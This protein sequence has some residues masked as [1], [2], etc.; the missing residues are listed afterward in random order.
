[1]AVVATNLKKGQCIN[2]K[3]EMGVVLGLDHRTPGKGNALIMAKIRSFQTG[4][5]KDI[6]FASSDKVDIVPA[7][8]KKVEYSYADGTGYFF[9]DPETYDTFEVP[10]DILGEDAGWLTENMEVEVLYVD[11]KLVSTEL[12]PSIEMEVTEAAEGLK[13]DTANNPQK[14]VTLSCGKTI[15]A[16][17]FVKEGD[18]VKV[19]P[20]SGEYLG[21]A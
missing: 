17:L 4:K 6:R 14:P 10:G 21:R 12:P 18:L 20:S 1:M 8:R 15:Q 9:M 19:D 16:P 2:Y 7:E 11:G 3:G 5:T 13:G